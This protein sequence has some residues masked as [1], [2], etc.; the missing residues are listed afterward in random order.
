MR[1][2]I[3]GILSGAC[4][5]LGL[6]G[7]YWY[8]SLSKEDRDRAD[9]LAGEHALRLYGKALNRLTPEEAS[10]VRGLVRDHSAA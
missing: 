10:H 2:P 6:Y 8:H 7:L 4:A 1:Y 3:V 9:R 5:A